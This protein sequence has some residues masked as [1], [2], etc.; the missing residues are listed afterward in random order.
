MLRFLKNYWF[1][2]LAALLVV[3]IVVLWFVYPSWR[4]AFCGFAIA[5]VIAIGLGSAARVYR[6]IHRD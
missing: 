5:A 1:F 2:I 3:A 4:R 6:S